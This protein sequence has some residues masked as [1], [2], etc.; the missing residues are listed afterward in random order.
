[1]CL[2]LLT[3][4]KTIVRVMIQYELNSNNTRERLSIYSEAVGKYT[5]F[6]NHRHHR[7]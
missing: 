6:H 2:Y 3:N 7:L 1:M 4:W 5:A